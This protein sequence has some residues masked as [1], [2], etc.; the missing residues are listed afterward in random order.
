[1]SLAWLVMR[2]IKRRTRGIGRPVSPR[3]RQTGMPIQGA[4]KKMS[5]LSQLRAA[6]EGTPLE[7]PAKRVCEHCQAEFEVRTVE[8]SLSWLKHRGRHH[9]TDSR[10]PPRTADSLIALGGRQS[11]YSP[12]DGHPPFADLLKWLEMIGAGRHR[13]STAFDRVQKKF[14][15]GGVFFRKGLREYLLDILSDERMPVPPTLWPDKTRE[16]GLL[17][18]LS[19]HTAAF[20]GRCREEL[21]YAHRTLVAA[22]AISALRPGWRESWERAGREVE[23]VVFAIAQCGMEGLQAQ[24]Q[25]ATRIALEASDD[26]DGIDRCADALAEL[27]YNTAGMESWVRAAVRPEMVDWRRGA[28]AEIFAA[29]S[30]KTADRRRSILQRAQSDST[31]C[32]VQKIKAQEGTP[33]AEADRPSLADRLAKAKKPR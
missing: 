12:D 17:E 16:E 3:L 29:A 10:K 6:L 8:G 7:R 22:D 15:R 19:A 32:E 30:Q 28:L 4:A 31:Y 9:Q 25:A 21:C 20:R 13:V 27:G 33:K 5:R 26:P 11:C 18:L 23:Q 24:E 1:M 2:M 14:N